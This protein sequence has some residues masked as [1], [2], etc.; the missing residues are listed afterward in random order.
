MVW[1][2]ALHLEV[3]RSASGLGLP[4][5]Y[6]SE[7]QISFICNLGTTRFTQGDMQGCHE[8][9]KSGLP[10]TQGSVMMMNRAGPIFAFTPRHSAPPT[11]LPFLPQLQPQGSSCYI[12]FTHQVCPILGGCIFTT[13]SPWNFFFPGPAYGSFFSCF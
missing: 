9:R 8:T 4:H 10:W 2:K 3:G 13:V 6:F 11:C 1:W 5:I 12:S 7:K